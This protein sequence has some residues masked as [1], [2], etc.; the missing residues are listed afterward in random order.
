MKPVHLLILAAVVSVMGLLFLLQG[1][2]VDNGDTRLP[3]RMHHS[4]PQHIKHKKEGKHNEALDHAGFDPE[5]PSPLPSH[6]RSCAVQCRLDATLR[7]Y[8]EVVFRWRTMRGSMRST[9]TRTAMRNG[10]VARTT[11]GGT[12]TTPRTVVASTSAIVSRCVRHISIS[13]LMYY[14]RCMCSVPKFVKSRLKLGERRAARA[15]W[16]SR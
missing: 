14:V 8:E 6:L 4:G 5:V 11:N 15:R 12:S 2:T 1:P 10:V 9:T 7:Y 3:R 13:L 16:F